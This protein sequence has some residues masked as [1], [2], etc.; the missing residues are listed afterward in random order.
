MQKLMDRETP[1][2][3][4]LYDYEVPTRCPAGTTRSKKRKTAEKDGQG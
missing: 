4:T 1:A 2:P 3:H